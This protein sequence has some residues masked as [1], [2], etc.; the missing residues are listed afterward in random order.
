MLRVSVFITTYS[1]IETF[2]SIKLIFGFNRSKQP[3]IKLTRYQISNGIDRLD[4]T[5]QKDNVR[6]ESKLRVALILSERD[7]EFV[8]FLFEFDTVKDKQVGSYSSKRAL[9]EF[10]FC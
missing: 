6:T 4:L 9:Y 2:A 10:C 7:N 5:D 1:S 3:S 8:I